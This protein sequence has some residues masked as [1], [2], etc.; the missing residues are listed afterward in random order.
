M[1]RSPDHRR[2]QQSPN[3]RQ[4]PAQPAPPTTRIASVRIIADDSGKDAFPP[5]EWVPPAGG[6]S[7]AAL[8]HHPGQA[9]DRQWVQSQFDAAM[10]GGGLQAS[11]ALAIV[12]H[13]N[14]AFITAGFINS[15][16]LVMPDSDLGSGVLDL[17]LVYGRLSS[18][19]TEAVSVEWAGGSAGLSE[20]Y[21]RARFPS[22]DSRPLNALMLE[23]DFRLLTED[24]MIRTVSASL[25][26]GSA[27]GEASLRVL[28]NPVP[29]FELYSGAANDR[30][31]SV[32]GERMYVGGLA[33]NA[34]FSG[35]TVS[36]EASLTKGAEAV[37]LAYSAPFLAPSTSAFI[38]AEL[39][40]AAVIDRPLIPL[41]IK[42][43]ER[44]V[45]GGIVQEIIRS[46]LM[47]TGIAGR[48][49]SSQQ[50]SVGASLAHRWQKSF[51]LGEPFSFAPGAVDGRTEYSALRLTADY[52]RR[53]T[54][55]VIA[56]SLTGTIGLGGTQSNI[57]GV[58][59]PDDHFSAFT[60]QLSAA[61]Q[62][63][64][65]LELRGRVVAQYA[66]GTLYSGERIAVGG[67]NSVRGYRES[68]YLADRGLL[69]SLELAYPFNLGGKGAAGGL[70]WGSFTAVIFG[71]AA[72]FQ[73]AERP[74]IERDLISSVG[75]SLAWT[76]TDDF[77]ATIT[78]GKALQK[79]V[80]ANQDDWQDKGL[81]FQVV[82]RPLGLLG[83]LTSAR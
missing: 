34:L 69:G 15:G 40:N 82:V 6:N 80:T 19:T 22:A 70:G 57:Q 36:G 63:G 2:P 11:T 17:R 68:L 12:Q 32:G 9:L 3:Q 78:Y 71:D 26:P 44:S 47:G 10:A 60:A 45:E 59:N 76:P 5:R 23:R 55:Q 72:K 41:D 79:T 24:E 1:R 39:N 62:I 61:K 54:D 74:R 37:Q 58:P 77:R 67:I 7:A 43:R 30:S 13:I 33:R 83:G 51:L 28:I 64:A 65:G 20:D 56:L 46:P 50:L 16:L 31:P 25:Q 18:A 66:P 14:R 52:V 81:H 48:W 73:N 38:R 4:A 49:A 53:N 75:A 27:P 8:R 21:I 35:D 29:R 42:S